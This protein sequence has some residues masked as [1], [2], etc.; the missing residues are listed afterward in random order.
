ME[1]LIPTSRSSSAASASVRREFVT[2]MGMMFGVG[3]ASGLL[4]LGFVDGEGG[5]SHAGERER[6]AETQA[7]ERRAMNE[8]SQHLDRL[9]E[10]LAA[11]FR[12]AATTFRVALDPV[13]TAFQHAV[14]EVL[15]T[16]PWGTRVSYTWVAERMGRPDAV[17]AVAA[18]NGANPIAIIVPC[19]R[20]VGRSGDLTGYAGGLE[21]KRRLLEIEASAPLFVASG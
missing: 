13:G 11:Y 6:L 2:P 21:R 19:H 7:A 3:R 16:I 12:G 14:W 20:V 10:E 4:A 17:R 15:R 8:A 18:A 5:S 9:E 1:S